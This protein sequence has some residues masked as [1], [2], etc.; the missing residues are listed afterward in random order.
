M[1]QMIDGF[2]I[3]VFFLL[4]EPDIPC[5]SILSIWILKFSSLFNRSEN[6]TSGAG[7]P[8]I[9]YGPTTPCMPMIINNQTIFLF[10]AGLG[11]IIIW[12][13]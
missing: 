4:Y 6:E 13:Q 3:R 5:T 8:E 11:N 10:L 2:E 7:E 9:E 1:R 12:L